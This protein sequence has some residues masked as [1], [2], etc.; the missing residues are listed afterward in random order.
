[1]IA[2]WKFDETSG[3]A[4]ADSSSGKQRASEEL[5]RRQLPLGAWLVGGALRQFLENGDPDENRDDLVVTDAPI[6]FMNQDRLRSVFET[7]TRW[8]WPTHT[9]C[10]RRTVIGI[11]ELGSVSYHARN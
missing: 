4:A 10:L 11:R 7:R 5:R 8:C 2:H 9:S 6:R 3:L 1:L